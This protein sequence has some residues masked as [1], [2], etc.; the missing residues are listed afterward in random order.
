[1]L[2]NVFGIEMHFFSFPPPPLFITEY[3]FE[4]RTSH[5]LGQCCTQTTPPALIYLSSYFEIRSKFLKLALNSLCSP[6]WPC[7]Y[8]LLASASCFS[9]WDYRPGP[10]A[11]AQH[12]FGDCFWY[13]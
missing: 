12:C 9:S 1:M 11:L 3:G 13:K 8:D 2:E 6:D 4:L 5:V 10:P 7:I